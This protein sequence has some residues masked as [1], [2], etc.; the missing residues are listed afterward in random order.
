MADSLP[1]SYIVAYDIANPKRLGRVHRLMVKRGIPLQY[2]VF[3]VHGN[4]RRLRDL[5]TELAGVIDERRDDIRAYPLPRHPE[6]THLGRQLFPDGI[7][8]SG[9]DAQNSILASVA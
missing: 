7:M 2:S 3:L 1:R 4:K 5:M 8:L 6:Y 9:V